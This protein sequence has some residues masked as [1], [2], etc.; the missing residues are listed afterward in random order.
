MF[1][2]HFS[3]ISIELDQ[4]EER[5]SMDFGSPDDYYSDIFDYYNDA[6]AGKIISNT[7]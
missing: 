5:A 1:Q 7:F 4:E 2:F 3:Y 6:R